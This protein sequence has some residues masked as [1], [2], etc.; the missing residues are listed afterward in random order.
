MILMDALNT[1]QAAVETAFT[2]FTPAPRA[3]GVGWPQE[4]LLGQ[5]TCGSPAPVIS[6]FDLN[7]G[8]NTT[9][10]L[11]QPTAQSANATGLTAVSSA[12]YLIATAG[13][14]LGGTVNA[15]DAV[16]FFAALGK[17]QGGVTVTMALHDTPSSIATKLAAA[18]NGNPVLST[19]MSAAAT[20]PVITLTNLTESLIRINVA[21]G[22]IGTRTTEGHRQMRHAQIDVWAG[23][24]AIRTAAEAVLSPLLT[25]LH[26]NFGLQGPA[27]D[28]LRVIYNS[29]LLI[30][31]DILK[32]IYRE[33]FDVNLEFG[34]SYDDTL[35]S[36][37]VPEVSLG[38]NTGGIVTPAS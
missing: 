6:I 22:N 5:I 16:G 24:A 8:T 13:L 19:W 31:T 29:G 10:W 9:R 12:V 34:E 36:V 23:T 20:G 3:I 1:L 27:Q 17:T 4:T 38:I 2:G 7:A 30:D 21:T 32:S 26:A 25:R 28:W 15:N 18:I 37:L 33:R 14:T 11:K 35:Y